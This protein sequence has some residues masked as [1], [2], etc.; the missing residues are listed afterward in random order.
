MAYMHSFVSCF[1]LL[2]FRTHPF[3]TYMLGVAI[4]NEAKVKKHE[5][6]NVMILLWTR[7]MNITR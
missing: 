6:I 2:L 7:D 3:D 1:V 5:S 4:A